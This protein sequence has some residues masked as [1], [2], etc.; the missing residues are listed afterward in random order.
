MLNSQ[1]ND[2]FN[3]YTF[4]GIYSTRAHPI[5]YEYEYKKSESR[6]IKSR[7]NIFD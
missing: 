2:I 6:R 7:K 5:N 3:A 1:I 4:N